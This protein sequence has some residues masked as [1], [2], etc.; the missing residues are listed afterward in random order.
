MRFKQLVSHADS[1]NLIHTPQWEE[2]GPLLQP[3]GAF[4]LPSEMSVRNQA[5]PAGWL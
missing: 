2:E 1:L 4:G 5:Q 3:P